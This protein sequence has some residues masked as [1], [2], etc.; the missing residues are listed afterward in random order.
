MGASV[1]QTGR[2]ADRRAKR[3]AGKQAGEQTTQ[4][5]R[6]DGWVPPPH[7]GQHLR[8]ARGGGREGREV[9]HGQGMGERPVRDMLDVCV[10]MML[11]PGL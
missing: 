4:T 5:D 1:C 11:V 10:H 2:Q 6:M 8:H 7:D 3:R 9:C